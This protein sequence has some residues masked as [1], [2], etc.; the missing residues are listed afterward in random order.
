MK[1]QTLEIKVALQILKPVNEVFEAIIDPTQMSAGN[2][3]KA[4]K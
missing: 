4:N 1:N 3:K 2:W